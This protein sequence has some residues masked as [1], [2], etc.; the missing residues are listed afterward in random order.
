M[1]EPLPSRRRLRLAH[2]IVVGLALLA[3]G[4]SAVLSNS[5][6][7]RLPHLEDEVAY[8]FQ[9]RTLAGGQ[10]VVETPQPR[11][12][13]WQPFIVDY[14]GQ[15][16]GK[17]SLGWPAQL[18]VGVLLGEEWIIN[19][20]F[21]ALTVALVYR[22]GRE[23]FGVE[24]GVVAAALVAFSPAAVLLN[25]TLMGHTTALFWSVAFV[26]AYW[27]IERGTHPLRW[28]LAAG[29]A[30]GLVLINRPATGAALAVPFAAYSLVR[31]I[32][33]AWPA[34]RRREPARP[35]RRL[36]A[37]FT[38][39]ALVTLALGLVIPLYNAA[40]TGDP[41]RNLY[42]FVW[43]YDRIGFGEGYGRH[44]HTLEK[45]VRHMRFDLSLT[46]ADLFGWQWP[47]LVTNDGAVRPELA[48]HFINEGDYYPAFGLSWMLLPLG[49]IVI[50]KW[51]SAYVFL[52]LALGLAWLAFP[53]IG[54]GALARDP[55]WAWV[56]VFG[57]LAWVCAP[58][59]VLRDARETWGWLLLAVILALIIFQLTYWIGSQRYST[60]YYFEGLFAAAILS[61]L[62][63]VWLA[64]RARRGVVYGAFA[65]V[66]MASMLLYTLPRVGVLYQFN[67]IDRRLID[68]VEARR[69]GDRDLLVIVTGEN[70]RWRSYGELMALT[71][72]YLDSPIVAARASSSIPRDEILA[73]F[74]DRQ[75]I[76]LEAQD[77]EA[78]FA[79]E[80]RP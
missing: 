75:V 50:Y 51:R 71:S 6:F 44:G 36:T 2:W 7:E 12:A 77:N 32:R 76:D 73:R 29:A 64:Q 68:Q 30:L 48:D 59:A 15:R 9:A 79:G 38:A 34:L 39:L 70:V 80:A 25:A 53:F 37:A 14:E 5:V 45:G 17:Y 46:A 41:T 62:P 24:T 35:L 23:L 63:V 56:T 69:E 20:C 13:Y 78:W 67:L 66:L 26:Y 49:L 74:P 52:W 19:A 8:L 11:L 3:F 31:L 27:R 40:A 16:F 72:P 4:L 43:D 21:A 1:I 65:V 22:L 18:A 42:R 55:V 60:R 58:L 47:P 33:L 10:L 28:G 54:D 61:A 57:L